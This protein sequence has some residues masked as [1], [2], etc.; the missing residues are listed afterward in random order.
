MKAQQLGARRRS[1]VKTLGKVLLRTAVFVVF[2]VVVG[3]AAAGGIALT[4]YERY[5]AQYVEPSE[6]SLNQPSAGAIILDRNGKL[7]YEYVDDKDGMRLPVKLEDV[8]P[9]FLAA[10]IATEDA[11][12]FKNPGVNSKGLVRA[13]WENFDPLVESGDPFRAPAAARSRSSWSRTSTSRRRS[14][15]RRSIDRKMR[16]IVYRHRADEALRQGADPRVVRQP[17]Q[18]R[19]R[20][21]RRR[22]REPGL[23]RQVREDLT[24][25][26]AALLAGIPQSPAPTTRASTSRRPWCGATRCST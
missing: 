13:A 4:T 18:L 10:T 9:A 5:A 25:A 17:D 15:A 16:E 3:V 11:S 1:P 22:G 24:L 19:R 7:L 2:L 26:E 14:A 21:Q 6:L 12:F 8:S 20:L 23:L